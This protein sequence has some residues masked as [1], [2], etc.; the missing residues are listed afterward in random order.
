M[1]KNK[2]TLGVKHLRARRTNT[3]RQQFNTAEE[4]RKSR[5]V[6]YELLKEKAIR[7][8]R[9]DHLT[10]IQ[11]CWRKTE[12][13][14]T[15]FHTRIIA[16]EIDRAIENFR[17]GISSY[18]FI[19]VHHRSGKS[20][21]VSRY[22]GPR[23]LGLF[24]DC[25]VMQ[26]TYASHLATKFS[27]FGRNLIQRKEYQEIFPEITLDPKSQAANDYKVFFEG[28]DL[29]GSL[30]SSGLISGLTGNGAHLAILDDYLSGREDAESLAL[31]NKTW[32]SFTNDFMTR[33]APTHIVIILAT[34]WH[35]D[36]IKGRIIKEMAENPDFPRFKFLIFPAKKED[37]KGPGIYPNQYLFEERL[38]ASWYK[39]QY[40]TLGLY[41]SSALLDCN[42]S[43]R[44]AAILNTGNIIY[45]E[46][47]IE[48]PRLR[49]HRIYDVAH[50]EKQRTGDDPD[51]TRGTLLAF[52]LR[53]GDPVPH[54]WIKHSWRGRYKAPERDKK[55]KEISELDGP[56]VKI[57]VESSVDAKDAVE[58]VKI[59]VPDRTVIGIEI[60]GRGDKVIRATPLEP[61]FDAPGHVHLLRGDWNFDFIDEI[62]HFDGTGGTHD[63]AIDNM[64]AGYALLMKN[65]PID[66]K[67]EQR[68]LIKA[69]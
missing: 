26:T 31:R 3:L 58:Y 38:G 36:D 2:K 33:L 6:Y 35:Y 37:Y 42:A 55:I 47:S 13:F 28:K 32:N 1:K 5:Q 51:Y 59:A 43:P 23:F 4:L 20:D 60:A 62:K 67:P 40:A 44:G 11:Y 52:E 22:L 19:S 54:L 57:G 7:E 12:P 29:Q 69:R 24:P 45:H 8:A 48:F 63:E 15:G 68:A 34:N 39:T 30:F 9:K 41:G 27:R 50:T 17:Q 66:L 46:D 61:I 65:K 14:I 56:Y 49:Y 16:E 53:E 21:L 64:S 25:E 18:I 10:F